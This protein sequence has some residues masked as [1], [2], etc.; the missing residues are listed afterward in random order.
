MSDAMPTAG[1]PVRAGTGDWPGGP[2]RPDR[3]DSSYELHPDPVALGR[4]PGGW[5]SQFQVTMT[6]APDRVR[7]QEETCPRSPMAGTWAT[8]SL[9]GRWYRLGWVFSAVWLVYL[10][11]P[12]SSVWANPDPFRRYLGVAT[13]LGFAVVFVVIFTAHRFALRQG[14]RLSRATGAAA[15][16]A[17]VIV[18]V[19]GYV[20]VGQPASRLL[21]Y[22]GVMA[23]FLLPTRAGWAVVAA[24]IAASLVVPALVPGWTSNGALSFGI[25]VSAL[26]CWGV[27][28]LIQ[29]NQ[30]LAAARNE[31][32]R[33]AL[34][35][36][37]NR[38]ARDLHDILGH[39]L[40]VVAVKAE[41][42]GRL[43][44]LDPVRAEAEIAD[45]ERIAR[46]ALAD[47]RSAASGYREV[48]LCGELASART[49]L[50][51]AGIEAGLPAGQIAAIPRLRQ[52][53][54]GWA[55]REGVTNVVRH[56]GA[57]RCVIRVTPDEVE[58]SD[59]GTGCAGSGGRPPDR[60]SAAGSGGPRPGNGLTGLRE[61]AEA[62]GAV[63]SVGRSALGGF[64]LRVR[65]P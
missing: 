9:S 20:T 35:D 14:R 15:M 65:M 63:V 1:A 33:L 58:I 6:Q 50:D 49:A 5:L 22:V 11:Q 16:T 42:A 18:T 44:R 30:Q 56:S 60:R 32:T 64:A 7:T 8:Q 31:I 62:E 45:V 41:L 34:A 24:A 26:A 46:Q 55:V 52:E 57:T 2:E 36:E 61:R 53:L 47:V 54:F 28:G 40:T 39:S 29:R 38:F 4:R 43:A 13:L 23:V 59:D 21:V 27:G 51:A 10:A 12:L 19:I 3:A 17:A 25:F 37:R 48:T